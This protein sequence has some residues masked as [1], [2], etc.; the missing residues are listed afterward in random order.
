MLLLSLFNVNVLI[1]D[2]VFIPLHMPTNGF[3]CVSLPLDEVALVKTLLL[4]MLCLDIIVFSLSLSY[5]RF[6]EWTLDCMSPA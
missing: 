4:E 2:V 1:K 5:L 3:L 6:E